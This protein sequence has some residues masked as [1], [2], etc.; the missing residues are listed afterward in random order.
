[1]PQSRRPEGTP[2]GGQVTQAQRHVGALRPASWPA[3]TY[4]EHPWHITAEQAHRLGAVE[5]RRLSRPYRAALPPQIADLD[6]MGALER[7]ALEAAED[8]AALTREFDAAMAALP[9]PMP[10]ILLR[11]ESASSS[12]IEN[13]TANAHNIAAAT[14]GADAK[15]NSALVA[16][17]VAAM[18]EALAHLGPLDLPT[19][20]SIHRALLATSQ[21]DAAGVLRGEQV[22]VGA[23]DQSPHGAAFVAPHSSLV[24]ALMGD[25]QR[26]IERRDMPPL[27]HAAIA[28]AQFE[29][30]HPFSD[31]NGRTGRVLVHSM[32]RTSVP[33]TSSTVPVSAGLLG[34]TGSYVRALTD[35]R[36]GDPGRIVTSMSLAAHDAARYGRALAQRIVETRSGWVSSIDARSDSAAWRLADHLFSQPVVNAAHVCTALDVSDRGARNAIT[37]LVEAGVLRKAVL[38][39]RRNVVWQADAVLAAMDDFARAAARRR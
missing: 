24:P 21:P 15:E 16:A 28:H 2:A 22:W 36:D 38:G 10:A 32:L 14:I 4:E 17:N 39:R 18:H 6:V 27:V 3:L 29:T 12:Q 7:S 11:S 20:L 37:K 13:L 30:I 23:S 25:L 33:I 31:G 19:I 9:V 26:F 34:D 1:M 5:T 8:A 35:Y